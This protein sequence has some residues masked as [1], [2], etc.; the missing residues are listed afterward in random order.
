M[1]PLNG[2]DYPIGAPIYTFVAE[3]GSNTHVDSEKLREWCAANRETLEWFYTPVKPEIAKSFERDN[4]IDVV[5][6]IRVAS[7][8][9]LDPIIYGKT[10]TLGANGGPDVI[11][12]D[13]HHR[14]Y[15][16]W[17]LGSD[18]I[19]GYVLEPEQWR[20][21]EIIGLPS[22]TEEQLRRAPTSK[23]KKHAKG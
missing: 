21:F 23:G 7:M 12:I 20:E 17:K 14:Y 4:V 15:V 3:D 5:H 18:M 1:M 6:A 13:G 10:G 9:K 22:L 8:D 11:L 19:P 2:K 16:A